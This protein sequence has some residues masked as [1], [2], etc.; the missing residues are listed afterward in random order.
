MCTSHLQFFIVTLYFE[1]KKYISKGPTLITHDEG[2]MLTISFRCSSLVQGR[3][4]GI[5]ENLFLYEHFK[6][7][8]Q[9]LRAFSNIQ[10]SY[11]MKLMAL[12]IQI[13]YWYT[14]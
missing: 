8:S 2:A 4:S 1:V 3:G 14:G 9:G 13:Q 7:Q 12:N 11:N 6:V 10:Y 5:T